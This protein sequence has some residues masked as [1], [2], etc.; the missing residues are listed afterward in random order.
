MWKQSDGV[1]LICRDCV[2]KI[3]HDYIEEFDDQELAIKA[4][5]A[6]IDWPFVASVF[7]ANCNDEKELDLPAYYRNLRMKQNAIKNYATSMLD[8]ELSKDMTAIRE[9]R[10]SKWSK[11]D[12]QNMN[13]AISVVGYDPFDADGFDDEDRK[14]CFNTLA[15][16]CDTEGIRDDSHKRQA[17]VQITQLHL[18][19]RKVDQLINEELM[20][21]NP[22]ESKLRTLSDT[23][24]KFLNAISTLAKDNGL[25]SNYNDSSRAGRSTFTLKMKE[26]AE[27]GFEQV[28]PN[29]FDIHTAEAMKQVADISNKSIL[30]QLSLDDNDYVDMIKEQRTALQNKIEEC[31]KLEEE[32]RNLKN[33]LAD[34]EAG[35][36]KR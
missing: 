8:G 26:L 7:Y 29:L 10:D 22:N 24:S 19:C 20:L 2:A 27:Q 14:Y 1:A 5:C 34:Y 12:K 15:G 33:E 36:R 23:K 17:A 3:Y 31:E 13:F 18:Q 28:R 32:N 4:L 21:Q 11:K 35:S 30:D 9:W 6:L 16:Y 25:S